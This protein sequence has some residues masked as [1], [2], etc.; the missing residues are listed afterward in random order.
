MW[1]GSFFESHIKRV[2][3]NV[4]HKVDYKYHKNIFNSQKK[5]ECSIIFHEKL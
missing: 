1:Y 4:L 5:S 2:L 3:S